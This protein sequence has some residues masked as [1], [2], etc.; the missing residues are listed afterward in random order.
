MTFQTLTVNA[1]TGKTYWQKPHDSF[2]NAVNHAFKFTRNRADLFIYEVFEEGAIR[3]LETI[4]HLEV[5]LHKERK[6][7]HVS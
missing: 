2:K 7:A 5:E 6:E 1:M 4:T 3:L